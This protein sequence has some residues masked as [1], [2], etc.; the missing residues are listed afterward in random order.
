MGYSLRCC[1]GNYL[2]FGAHL[3]KRWSALRSRSE[4]RLVRPDGE[5]GGVKDRSCTSV[6]LPF[7]QLE[8]VHMPFDRAVAP[9][10]SQCGFYGMLIAQ[11]AVCEAA[12][13]G[14][15]RVKGQQYGEKSS[16][17]RCDESGWIYSGT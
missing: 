1:F 8:P 14:N 10:Q 6:H 15:G 2:G 9:G 7:D 5:H 17:L 16:I 3:V 11:E 13:G 4:H 12:Q